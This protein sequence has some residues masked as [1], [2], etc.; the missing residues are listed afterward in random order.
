MQ[1]ILSRIIALASIAGAASVAGADFTKDGTLQFDGSST[2]VDTVRF[3]VNGAGPIEIDLLSD[4]QAGDVNGD[5]E[6]AY[7]D[8]AFVIYTE[9]EDGSPGVVVA[10]SDD[11]GGMYPAYAG[12]DG[13]TNQNDP[14]MRYG[15]LPT[16]D[17][18]LYIGAGPMLPEEALTGSQA[19]NAT[20][21]IGG[22][23]HTHAD[24]RISGR[25]PVTLR[26]ERAP[27]SPT[28]IWDNGE[29]DGLGFQA[30]ESGSAIGE[31]RAAD[32]FTIKQGTVARIDTISVQMLMSGDDFNATLQLYHDCNGCPAD[33]VEC[34]FFQHPT[35]RIL[36]NQ[37]Q[38]GF[39][40]VE[41]TFD[42][43][44]RLE[45]DEYG[46]ESFVP[47]L[48]L[49][50]GKSYWLSPVGSGEL[51]DRA[52][53]MTTGDGDTAGA[54]A[55]FQSGE[56]KID[57]WLPVDEL[58]LGCADFAFNVEGSSCCV[59]CDNG[60]PD[61]EGA[62][63]LLDTTAPGAR[64]VD[65]F[66]VNGC[67]TREICFLKTW[68]ITNCDP[69]RMKAQLYSDDCDSP[70]GLVGE[71]V[72][73]SKSVQ[74]SAPE[75]I[76]VGGVQ[77]TAY[78]VEFHDLGWAV[79]PGGNYW[80]SLH[81]QGTGSFSERSYTAFA[82]D[83]REPGCDIKLSQAQSLRRVSRVL[84]WHPLSDVIGM[85]RDLAF[86]LAVT[87]LDSDTP[88]GSD[89]TDLANSCASDINNDGRVSA[90]DLTMFL[91]M[92]FNGCDDERP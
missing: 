72:L 43:S 9:P 12:V 34:G 20:R 14:Y 64:L 74:I 78:R 41:L 75:S 36:D 29:F 2:S 56:Y 63:P 80:V 16:G 49:H 77:L 6:I 24:Y 67:E 17:Y 88:G 84:E 50:G 71:E 35:V 90:I 40:A 23:P 87:P 1:R 58:N 19:G 76:D 32:D 39:T 15:G 85:P 18:V 46:N 44:E 47:G 8:A 10:L 13:S 66:V 11:A 89:G 69:L 45:T 68:I 59:I 65:N 38:P 91:E 81:H 48:W 70:S 28:C 73:A 52:F 27:V 37:P 26:A 82:T 22:L 57:A 83:C 92:W 30:S 25:G 60:L 51:Y 21:T 31:S 79:E 55:K 5:G 62:D 53:W 42:T 7:L 61:L 4:E 86:K 54:T 3:R 33:L